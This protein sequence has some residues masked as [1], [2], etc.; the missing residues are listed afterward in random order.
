M[1]PVHVL[2]WSDV[3]FRIPHS[4]G[5]GGHIV[6]PCGRR[7]PASVKNGASLPT[8]RR[9]HWDT[10]DMSEGPCLKARTSPLHVGC[11]LPWLLRFPKE[12][13]HVPGLYAALE[14]QG[15]C[16]LTRTAAS[17]SLLICLPSLSFQVMVEKRRVTQSVNLVFSHET[18]KVRL[19]SS[20][21]LTAVPSLLSL[22]WLLPRA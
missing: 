11:F 13:T 6:V 9:L 8:L 7:S 21:R 15:L 18:G 22:W 12:R 19:R 14:V 16:A 1:Y 20:W 2:S 17:N 5:G 10:A 3:T 4:L